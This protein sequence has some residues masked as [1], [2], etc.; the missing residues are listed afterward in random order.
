MNYWIYITTSTNWIVTKTHHLLGVP[1]R[2]K[3]TVA[4]LRKGD[5]CLIYVKQERVAGQLSGP[6]IV[7]DYE[8][9]SEV[10]HD[11]KRIFIN[12]R[13]L[14]EKETFNLRTN[15]K[16]R[17]VFEKP[18]EFAPLVKKLGFITNKNNYGTHLEGRALIPIGET[19]YKLIVSER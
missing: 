3:N 14:L 18:I 10:F 5:S 7:G 1:E 11:Q 15:L 9:A 6:Y 16:P 12:P 2:N 13:G 4:K 8:I 19:D 17:A